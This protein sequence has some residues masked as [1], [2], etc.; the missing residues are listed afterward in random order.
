MGSAA[1]K[2]GTEAKRQ[3]ANRVM[4]KAEPITVPL[5]PRKPVI[6]RTQNLRESHDARGAAHLLRGSHQ[7]SGGIISPPKGPTEAIAAAAED[8]MT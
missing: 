3:A 5:H 2:Y 1:P 6:K 7:C 8:R 4:T